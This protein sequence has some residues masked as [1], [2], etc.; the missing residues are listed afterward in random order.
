VPVFVASSNVTGK[1][2]LVE[3]VPPA[4][5]RRPRAPLPCR[6]APRKSVLL[7]G[8]YR[9]RRD[10]SLPPVAGAAADCFQWLPLLLPPPPSLDLLVPDNRHVRIQRSAPLCLP[11]GNRKPLLLGRF[12]QPLC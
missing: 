7:L 11:P 9:T 4:Y 3:R 10:Q 1:A 2:L 6:P 12:P 5:A 8:Q